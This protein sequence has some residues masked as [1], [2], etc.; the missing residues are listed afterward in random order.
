MIETFR[1][2]VQAWECDHLGHMNFQFYAAKISDAGLVT[3]HALGVTPSHIRQL[4]SALAVV[5]EHSQYKRELLAGDVIKVETGVVAI[6][7]SSVTLRH[8][9]S[10]CATGDEV[11]RST[12]VCVHMDLTKRRSAPMPDWLKTR[13]GELLIAGD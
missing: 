13:A 11:M 1:G 8:V 10:D 6:G 5:D 3:M 12:V 7:N 4:I 9:M 2:M